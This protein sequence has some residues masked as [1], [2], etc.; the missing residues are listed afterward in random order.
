MGMTETQTVALM[1]MD[2]TDRHF[3]GQQKR[4]E[5]VLF[6]RLHPIILLPHVAAFLVSVAFFPAIVY[7]LKAIS[8][9][10]PSLLMQ[11]LFLALFVGYTYFFHFF[12]NKILNYYLNIVI[13]TNYRVIIL[14]KTVFFCNN[15]DTIDLYK[16]QDL[17]KEQDGLLCTILDYGSV[18]IEVSAIH[19]T[20]TIHHIPNPEKWFKV[21]NKAKRQYIE[22]RRAS[23]GIGPKP[24]EVKRVEATPETNSKIKVEDILKFEEDTVNEDF[25][26]RF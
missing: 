6:T 9:G 10:A 20:K 16:I 15:K 13:L 1:K 17:K 12:F 26:P 11:A 24:E 21:L 7:G 25:L 8:P 2:N 18:V 4:E 14:Q 19:E 5:I 3:P 23:R 22:K